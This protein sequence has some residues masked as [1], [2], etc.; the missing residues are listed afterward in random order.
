MPISKGAWKR[1]GTADKNF[2]VWST[3]K[4]DDEFPNIAC[5]FQ[6]IWKGI[7]IIAEDRIERRLWKWMRN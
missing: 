6:A 7:R 1:N 2:L 5:I 3:L 4:I